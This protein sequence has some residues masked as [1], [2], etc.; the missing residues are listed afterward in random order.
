MTEQ[1]DPYHVWLGIAPKDQPPNHYRL[2]SVDLFETDPDVIENDS[3]LAAAQPPAQKNE[4]SKPPAGESPIQ[5]QTEKVTTKP[6]VEPPEAASPEPKPGTTPSPATP[7][8]VAPLPQQQPLPKPE[9]PPSQAA[10]KQKSPVPNEAALAQARKAADALFKTEIEKAD[11]FPGKVALAK[12]LLARALDQIGDTAGKFVLMLMAQDLAV[13][14]GDADTAFQVIDQMAGAFAVDRFAMKTDILVEWA[15]N[16]RT[17][18]ARKRLVEQAIGAGEEAM[19]A[20][21]LEAAKELGKLATSKSSLLRDKNLTQQ[22]KA[23][24]QR[25][26]EAGKDSQELQEA[27]A[28]LA[29]D[30]QHPQAN[31]V[32]GQYLCFTKGDWEKGLPVPSNNSVLVPR[33][34][35]APLVA[36]PPTE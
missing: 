35:L 6:A 26:T 36:A 33:Q 4:S 28:T 27:R 17:P 5:P 14:A 23:Y 29:K 7:P 18:D 11:T 3:A 32:V 20:G 25:L 16:A 1:F 12:R 10:Q 30:S 9:T 31:L 19:D 21:N 15:R 13:A 22:L 2:L 34:G 24:R 8:V